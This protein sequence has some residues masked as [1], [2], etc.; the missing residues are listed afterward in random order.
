MR[1][2]KAEDPPSTTTTTREEEDVDKTIIRTTGGSR[3]L[4]ED[5]GEEIDG[6]QRLKE[7]VYKLQR[8]NN[9]EPVRFNYA[10]LLRIN[11]VK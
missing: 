6:R 11:V 3:N 7:T 10:N 9:G 1:C 8:N 4:K 5:N 2:L